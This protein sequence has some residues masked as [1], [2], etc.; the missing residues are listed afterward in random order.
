MRPTLAL[1]AAA[2]A[3]AASS[4]ALAANSSKIPASPAS[5]TAG[6]ASLELVDPIDWSGRS[7]PARNGVHYGLCD[8]G[9]LRPCNLGR[10]ALAARRQ[11]VELARAAFRNT[12]VDLVVVGLPQSPTRHVLLVFERDILTE[13]R[14]P[15]AATA[16]R[17]YAMGTLV[18]HSPTED[19][20]VLFRL[21]P[22]PGAR[23]S[24]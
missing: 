9:P 1:V 3:V 21:R 7:I 2:V 23:S 6:V 24:R 19:S 18:P 13:A 14:D 11:A 5:T 22:S 4:S 16:A 15:L 10:G 12:G 20:L 17:L 8:R